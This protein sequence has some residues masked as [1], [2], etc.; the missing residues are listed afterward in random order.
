MPSFRKNFEVVT[1][2]TG[3]QKCE[4]MWPMQNE[5]LKMKGSGE[6][7]HQV[8][9]ARSQSPGV[10]RQPTEIRRRV[11]PGMSLKSGNSG[12]HRPVAFCGAPLRNF[13]KF[14]F[15]GGDANCQAVGLSHSSRGQ[16]ACVR[17]RLRRIQNICPVGAIQKAFVHPY[18]VDTCWGP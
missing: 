16:D 15:V 12:P 6:A 14:F 17:P 1:T 3:D 5:K 11:C 4:M 9:K 13:E 10:G 8:A 7:N 2:Q 18:R